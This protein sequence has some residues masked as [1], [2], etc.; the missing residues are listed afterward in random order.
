MRFR[1]TENTVS[2]IDS[3]GNKLTNEQSSYFR[4]SKV[5]DHNGNLL[6]CYHGTDRNFDTFEKGDIGFHF[7]TESAANQRR[8]YRDNPDEWYVDKYYLNIENYIDTYDFGD[9]DGLTVA[10]HILES[11][12]LDLNDEEIRWLQVISSSGGYYDEATTKQVRDF[13]IS[14][15]IDGFMYENAYEDEGS[16]SFIVFSP[17]Q[18]KRVTNQSP[19]S[20]NNLDESVTN[21]SIVNIDVAE[22]E[23]IATQFVSATPTYQ[24]WIDTQ[25]RFLDASDL[26]SHYAMI[27]EV[28]WQLTDKGKYK[29]VSPVELEPEDY[30]RMTDAIF[31]SFLELGWIQ[32]GLDCNFAS[33]HKK[34]TSQQYDAIEKYLDYAF[35]NKNYKMAICINNNGFHS[36]E[37]NLKEIPPEY[38]VGRIKR[39][40]A[41]GTLYEKG[42]NVK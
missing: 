3:L 33:M 25:G 27:D 23:D 37:Y 22:A 26:G 5:R 6:V 31:E 42:F 32:I 36:V 14:K 28:F 18:V 11:R 10:H 34:P 2:D 7:G 30:N 8:E 41:S 13:L 15:G 39:C 16:L 20:S 9:W 38:V 40:F 24:S 35:N 19:T 12:L 4:N 17:N 21:E 29:D 1:L